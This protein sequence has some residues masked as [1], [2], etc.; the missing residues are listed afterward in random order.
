[1]VQGTMKWMWTT[2]GTRTSLVVLAATFL[3]AGGCKQDAR[4]SAQATS[5]LSGVQVKSASD[6]IRFETSAAEFVLNASGYLSAA[7]RNSNGNPT[8]DQPDTEAGQ[9]ITIAGKKGEAHDF[10]LDLEHASISETSG[11][12]GNT[13]KRVEVH[14]T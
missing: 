7:L 11:K 1:M 3:S 2:T 9:G 12:L 10:K 4:P 5:P 6:G 13:G 8:L 14:G